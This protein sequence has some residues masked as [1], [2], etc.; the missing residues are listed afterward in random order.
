MPGGTCPATRGE[1]LQRPGEKLGQRLTA[2]DEV[3][4][5]VFQQDEAEILDAS[6]DEL[7]LEKHIERIDHSIVRA[8]TVRTLAAVC[9]EQ[10]LQAGARDDRDLLSV[11]FLKPL[12]RSLQVVAELGLLK[13]GKDDLK[14]DQHR[15]E[16]EDVPDLKA[17]R[18]KVLSAALRNR[19]WP[20]A[21]VL[22]ACRSP[23]DD[24]YI[25]GLNIPRDAPG[26]LLDGDRV[27]DCDA[28]VMRH[29]LGTVRVVFTRGRW[30][31]VSIRS[32]MPANSG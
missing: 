2:V 19:T 21:S 13:E 24:L 16:N 6:L 1:R 23:G 29:D 18:G 25:L 5:L 11:V 14:R 15:K 8:F 32:L 20:A 7:L 31:P 3:D 22:P 9:L 30:T 27:P 28:E 26:G 17:V 10:Q 12:L 4:P